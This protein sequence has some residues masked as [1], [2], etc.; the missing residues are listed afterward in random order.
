MGNVGSS[1]ERK[2]A[3]KNSSK[4]IVK[5]NNKLERI[6]DPTIGKVIRKKVCHAFSPKSN[7][8]SSR[9]LSKHSN[10][11]INI[12]TEKRKHIKICPAVTVTKLNCMPANIAKINNPTPMII[13]GKTIGNI[14]KPNTD[15]L[16]GNKY[17]VIALATNMPKIVLITEAKIPTL[18]L[19]KRASCNFVFFHIVTYL[20]NVQSVMGNCMYCD[21]LKEKRGRNK[22]GI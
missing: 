12:T 20:S 8:A 4:E 17:L 5:V 21:S 11:E 18:I 13:S 19:A 10:L 1:P 16:K 22:T 2:K 6:P 7:E 15:L 9:L 3:I 14:M